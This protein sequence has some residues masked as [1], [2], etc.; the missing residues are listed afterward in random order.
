MLSTALGVREFHVHGDGKMP[1]TV[2][3]LRAKKR[4]AAMTSVISAIDLGYRVVVVTDAVG[5]SKPR[6]H[7]SQLLYTFPRFDHQIELASTSEVCG[8]LAI[9]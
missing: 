1:D 6:S 4:E 8:A 2:I 3:R 7:T 9:T 5:S